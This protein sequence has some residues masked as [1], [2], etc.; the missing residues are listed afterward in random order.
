MHEQ[1]ALLR[2]HANLAIFVLLC[3]VM[4]LDNII[5]LLWVNNIVADSDE[6]S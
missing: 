6:R 2:D 3:V 4:V 5:P 1:N